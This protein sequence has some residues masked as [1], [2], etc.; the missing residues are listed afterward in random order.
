MYEK[1]R[2]T[3]TN[4]SGETRN[5]SSEKLKRE[6]NI[7]SDNYI[8]STRTFKISKKGFLVNLERFTKNVEYMNK[9]TL[10]RLISRDSIGGSSLDKFS[11]NMFSQDG[12][13]LEPNR[14][15]E[16]SSR[17]IEEKNWNSS[18]AELKSSDKNF[19]NIFQEEVF[20]R[21]DQDFVLFFKID[22]LKKGG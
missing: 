18:L 12:L 5:S 1:S 19:K 2:I 14:S 15:I 20:H 9:C 11:E 6:I 22:P 7:R 16:V 10:D 17:L 8:L 21:F 3:P 13:N 4:E